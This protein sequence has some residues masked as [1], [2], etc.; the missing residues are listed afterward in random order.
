MTGALPIVQAVVSLSF[1][2]LG[3]STVID[4][5]RRRER[6]IGY[7]ALALG[8]L[9]L[10]SIL[11]QLNPLTHY[12]LGT[13]IGD[14]TL[15][16]LMT[17]GYALLL[18]RDSFI[19]LSR[20]LRI[21]ALIL[22]VGTTA[23]A[24][25]VMVPVSPNVRPTTLQSAATIALVLVWT[26]CVTEP[27]VRLWAASRGRPAV[28]RARLR[29]LG[30]GYSAIVVILLVA[31]FS[32]LRR[33]WRQAE[34]D[35]LRDAVHDL[36]LFSPDRPT[37]AKRAADW[38]LR[39]VGADGIGIVDANG[40]ILALRGLSDESARQLAAHA[41][42][43]GPPQL[44]ATSGSAR[45]NAIVLPLPLDAGMG[46]MVLVSG[47]YTPFFGTDEVSRLRGYAANITAALDRARVTER[48][49][50][51][52]KTKSQFLNL[53]SHELRSPLGVINGYLSMLEQGVFGQLTESGV[54]ALEV[55]KAKTVEMNLLVAQ[56]LDA[57][58]LEDGRLALKRDRLDLRDIAQDA[59]EVVR[60]L[61][62]ADHQLSLEMP[63]RA[64]TVFGD[65]GRILTIIS[66]LLENAIK[67]SPQGGTVL[68]V[69]SAAEHAASV[70]VVDT[71][72]GI[73][74]E[75]L[76]RLFNR[77]ERIQNVRTSHV[78]GTGLGLYLSRE[79]ARQHGGD[80]QVESRPG[81]GSRFTLTLPL[82]API[83]ETEAPVVAEP[84]PPRLHVLT[85][86]AES[87]SQPA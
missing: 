4:W 64:V 37:L 51:L 27:I 83:A 69:V 5:L 86:D 56:M 2:A 16:L 53:A 59:M 23:A 46:A 76:P 25:V 31:V 63:P 55:L 44:L 77:F 66:N 10:T 65:V 82:A 47:P 43:G 17:S 18:F 22:C 50:A 57:A 60:P 54:R 80:I 35:Q 7:L 81:A 45:E 70:S 14:I 1:L 41:A 26:A 36:V 61:A 12:R 74:R 15:V 84:E 68:C 3:L 38:G 28:Q 11:G 87:E 19:P 9:G 13:L 40:D 67:Y 73:A 29:A 8:T 52:E 32:W 34:E 58:R 39:L 33:L 49:A 6:S 21:G 20:Q 75:D 48:L 30:G 42:G 79:L 62:G 85:P 78:A 71:G 24:L 72:I